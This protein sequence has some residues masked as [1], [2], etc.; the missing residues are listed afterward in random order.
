MPDGLDGLPL[1][2][3]GDGTTPL[4]GSAAMTLVV[5]PALPCSRTGAGPDPCRWPLGRPL[6]PVHQPCAGVGAVPFLGSEALRLDDEHPVAI[7]APACKHP[8]PD[9]HRFGKPADAADAEPELHGG[10]N[11]VHILAARP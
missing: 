8:Q 5:A 6:K 3:A 2:L 10:G 1:V 7:H 4:L 9:T 11:L